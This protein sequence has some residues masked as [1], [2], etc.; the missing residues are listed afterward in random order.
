M[1][2]QDARPGFTKY[3]KADFT[4]KL[5][6]ELNQQMPGLLSDDSKLDAAAIQDMVQA[7]IFTKQEADQML[8]D[9][10][11]P[12]TKKNCVS[13][14]EVRKSPD[15]TIFTVQVTSGDENDIEYM[16][17]GADGLRMLHV[18]PSGNGF[19]AKAT[20]TKGGEGYTETLSGDWNVI[21]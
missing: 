17:T 7:G 3:T 12:D 21:Q 11:T 1:E 10:N 13:E 6:A 2:A 5:E 9:V 16:R 8:Q 14:G 4:A 19:T 18:E 20:F 15:G